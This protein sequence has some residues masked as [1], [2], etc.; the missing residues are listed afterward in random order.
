M[1]AARAACWHVQSQACHVPTAPSPGRSQREAPRALQTR[2]PSSS[3][4]FGLICKWRIQSDRL[5]FLPPTATQMRKRLPKLKSQF[6]TTLNKLC[7][8]NFC[9]HTFCSR[10]FR[11]CHFLNSECYAHFITHT[12]ASLLACH[13]CTRTSCAQ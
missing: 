4:S 6:L 1:R 11:C 5:C 7:P 10:A 13:A 12:L 9:L 2:H 8:K 3:M